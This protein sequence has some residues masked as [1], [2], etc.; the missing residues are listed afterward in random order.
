MGVGCGENFRGRC[1]GCRMGP[2]G[3]HPEKATASRELFS[4]CRVGRKS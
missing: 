1:R 3:S 4:N 2:I